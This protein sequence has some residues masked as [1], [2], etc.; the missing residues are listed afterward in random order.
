MTM[1]KTVRKA[2]VDVLEE[3][4]ASEQK[5]FSRWEEVK[6]NFGFSGA[7][8]ELRKSTYLQNLNTALRTNDVRVAINPCEFMA[9]IRKWLRQLALHFGLYRYIASIQESVAAKSGSRG[10]RETSTAVGEAMQMIRAPT[11]SKRRLLEHS[12]L[13]MSEIMTNPRIPATFDSGVVRTVLR[14]KIKGKPRQM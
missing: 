8:P 14:A 2:V 13:V 12:D 7:L 5:C 3:D 11:E 6:L 10:Q 1:L 4:S 9:A